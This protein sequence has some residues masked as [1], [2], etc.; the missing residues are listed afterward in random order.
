MQDDIDNLILADQ[1]AQQCRRTIL[2]EIQK[3]FG[4][5]EQVSI[6]TTATILD[7]RFKKYFFKNKLV[8]AAAIK[9]SCQVRDSWIIPVTLTFWMLN[10]MKTLLGVI[11][12]LFGKC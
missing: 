2:L 8:V 4:Q 10:H 3:R 6:L 12:E 7:P 11:Q 9:K 1:I 5:M